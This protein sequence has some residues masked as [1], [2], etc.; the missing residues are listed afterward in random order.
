MSLGDLI[1]IKISKQWTN[2]QLYI[3]SRFVLHILVVIH[4][5]F[6]DPDHVGVDINAD[7]DVDIDA[8]IDVDIDADID[9]NV[10]I[11]RLQQ[12]NIS[13]WRRTRSASGGVNM[14]MERGE[15]SGGEPEHV[16]GDHGDGHHV[17]G[18]Q[19]DRVIFH[20]DSNVEEDEL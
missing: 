11:H 14:E 4:I 6:G 5:D 1:L 2:I 15:H 7:I 3:R 19:V 18:D 20:V 8:D 17:D 13:D 9:D 16:D 12:R 10:D